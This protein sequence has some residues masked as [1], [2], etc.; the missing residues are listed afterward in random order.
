MNKRQARHFAI[1]STVV[2]TIAFLVLTLDSHRQFKRLTNGDKITA[3][4]TRGKDVWHANNCINCHTLFGEGA[5]YAPD[6][7]KIT[8]LRG[9]AYLTAYMKDPSKFYDETRHRRLMPKQDISDTDIAALIAF[10]DWVSNVDNQGWPPRPLLV[11]GATFPGTDASAVA[12]AATPPAARAATSGDNPIAL[13]ERLFRSATPAC[14]ACHS[15]APGVDMAG[16]S[17]A[18]LVGRSAAL[19]AGA[20]YRG[21]ATDVDGYIRES[22][23]APSAHVVP[24]PMYSA[25]GQSFMPTTYAQDMSPEQLTQLVAYLSSLK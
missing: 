3:Q 23:L 20:S 25:D 22:V 19:L 7:T 11:T 21:K 9:Q 14:T 24:G 10:L 1:G 18:G 12:P 15:S 8:K 5:Y 2:A 4:V 6:L 17:L 16:P 13:G